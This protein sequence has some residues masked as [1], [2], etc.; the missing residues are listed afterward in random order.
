M[1]SDFVHTADVVEAVI[2][3]LR[4]S[5]AEHVNGL[6]AAWFTKT[7]VEPILKLLDHGDLLDY[8][9]DDDWPTTLCPAIL[10]R[11]MGTQRWEGKQAGDGA[12]TTAER[13][14]V[15]HVRR[16]DQCYADAG[17]VEKNMS[18]ARERYAKI[19]GQA[20]FADQKALLATIAQD[21]TR[22]LPT[23][24]TADTGGAGI[25]SAPFLSW[26]LG[27]GQGGAEEVAFIRE[28]GAAV[29]VWGIA[30]DLQVNIRTGG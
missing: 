14:R 2:A 18:R 25:I 16:W 15:L 27:Q 7:T 13:V 12:L 17:A 6:P 5:G 23:L 9:A 21:G 24:T 28:I 20:L 22:T 1:A 10:V 8:V 30:C 11:G 26:D 29:H 19:I 3:A 4:G